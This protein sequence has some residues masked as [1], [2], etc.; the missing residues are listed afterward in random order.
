MFLGSWRPS[1]PDDTLP[2]SD[3]ILLLFA[4]FS[5][6]FSLSSFRISLPLLLNSL[7]R[8]SRRVCPAVYACTTRASYSAPAVA[9]SSVSLARTHSP[10]ERNP[11][12]LPSSVFLSLSL[13]VSLTRHE[14]RDSPAPDYMFSGIMSPVSE[15]ASVVSG[16]RVRRISERATS[17]M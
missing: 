13:S 4:P 7:C 8:V 14:S 10:L 11:W 17:M 12:L 9:M 5:L 15:R 1:S 3:L 16:S 6:S 2:L